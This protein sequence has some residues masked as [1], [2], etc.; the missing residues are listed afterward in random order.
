MDNSNRIS[1]LVKSFS[2]AVMGQSDAINRGDPRAG[3]KMAKQY[4][5]AFGELR[6]FGDDGREALV[7]LLH[8]PR[9]DVRVMT[10]AFLLRYKTEDALSVLNAEALGTSLAALG[11]QECIQRWKD[12]S[13]SLD[14]I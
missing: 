1:S 9:A 5:S 4:I 11:A 13:W 8:Y 2:E 3:N 7:P 14:P 6:T 10:A 12:G